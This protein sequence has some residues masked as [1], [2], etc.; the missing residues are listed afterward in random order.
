MRVVVKT[1]PLKYLCINKRYHQET[2]SSISARTRVKQGAHIHGMSFWRLSWLNTNLKE[3]FGRI[4]VPCSISQHAHTTH[5]MFHFENIFRLQ[6]TTTAQRFEQ[7]FLFK[8]GMNCSAQAF[9]VEARKF[10]NRSLLNIAW[11]AKTF[12]ITRGKYRV[13]QKSLRQLGKNGSVQSFWGLKNR[14][15]TSTKCKTLFSKPCETTKANC[16]ITPKPKCFS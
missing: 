14:S 3:N 9:G 16:S 7:L 8:L 5:R 6:T 13:T 10:D 12:K 1:F 2:L 11:T 4:K 15:F